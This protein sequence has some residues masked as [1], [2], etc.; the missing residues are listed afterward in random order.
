MRI[1]E[2]YVKIKVRIK[3]FFGDEISTGLTITKPE[4][5]RPKHR[6]GE[7][8]IT[9][10]ENKGSVLIKCWK[11]GKELWVRKSSPCHDKGLCGNCVY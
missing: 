8:C 9:I 2:T 6:A 3:E 11:C 1:S 4:K 7:H 5:R 10:K